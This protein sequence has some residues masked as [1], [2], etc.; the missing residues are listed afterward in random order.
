MTYLRHL[1]RFL[2]TLAHELSDENAYA[3]YLASTGHTHSQSEWRRFS[4]DRQK[5]K[6]RNAKC[7]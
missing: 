7:C 4:E 6:Y 1:F 5:K 2:R 3:R